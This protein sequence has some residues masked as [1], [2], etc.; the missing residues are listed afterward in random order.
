MSDNFKYDITFQTKILSAMFMDKIFFLSIVDNIKIEYFTSES[1]K[2]LFGLIKDYYH[3]YKNLPTLDVIKNEI[4]K[5]EN[6]VLRISLMEI[7]PKFLNFFQANDLTYV[8]DETRFFCKEQAIKLSFL[9]SSVELTKIQDYSDFEKI[10]RNLDKAFMVGEDV[11]GGYSFSANIQERYSEEGK[12][13]PIPT[14]FDIIDK[15]NLGGGLAPGELG[16]VAAGS[17]IGKSWILCFIGLNAIKQGKNVL[18]Y[19]F[20]L[21]ESYT[22]KRYDVCLMNLPNDEIEKNLPLLEEKTK[23]LPGKLFIKHFT[24]RAVSLTGIKANIEKNI[25]L[26][27]K[28]DLIILDYADL[29]NAGGYGGDKRVALEDLYIDIRAMADE[30]QIPIWTATQVNREGYK[31]DVAKGDNISESFGK[32]FTADFAMSFSRSDKDKEND[33]GKMHIIKTRFG[34]DGITYLCDVNLKRGVLDVFDKNST[35]GQEINVSLGNM[36]IDTLNKEYKNYKNK[37]KNSIEI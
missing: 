13:K 31:S 22:S 30:I 17:G 25:M 35:R 3:K 34:P 28:P 37:Q 23:E 36:D 27:N 1:L 8:K 11:S 33:C 12:R 19:T 9:D 20:E 10:K 2:W 14:G 16:V 7:I 32:L 4:K 24:A 6:D 29:I 15:E 5:I 26:G 18:H 21:N